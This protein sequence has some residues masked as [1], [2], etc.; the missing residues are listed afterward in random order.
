M[1]PKPRPHLRC[2]AAGGGA[3][4]QPFIDPIAVKRAMCGSAQWASTE[5]QDTQEF[6]VALLDQVEHEVLGAQVRGRGL[7]GWELGGA[8]TSPFWRCWAKVCALL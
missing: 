3:G 8:S 4:R 2:S 7:W 1:T 6:F 5:Q